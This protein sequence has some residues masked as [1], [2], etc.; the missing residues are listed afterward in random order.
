MRQVVLQ[1]FVSLDGYSCDVDNGIRDVMM[2]IDDPEQEEYF[3]SRLRQAGTHI[4]GGSTYQVMAQFWPTSSHPSAGAMNDIPKVVFSRTM[5]SANDWPE[6][7]IASGDTAEEIAKLKAEPGGEI[8]AHGGTRFV[9]SLIRLGLVDQ[10]R[11][12]VL[13]AAAGRG[14]P[15]FTELD[16]PLKLRLVKSTAFPSGVLELVYAP[17]GTRT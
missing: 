12:W 8:L 17:V 3:V 4:M 9:R 7:R 16:H 2:E 15:L 13:P 10:Y 11:L 5:T 14:A 6:T 1:F